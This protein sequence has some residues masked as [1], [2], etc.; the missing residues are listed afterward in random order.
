MTVIDWAVILAVGTL[1]ALIAVGTVLLRSRHRALRL[2]FYG[3]VG[4]IGVWACSWVFKMLPRTEAWEVMADL[5]VNES[6]RYLVLGQYGGF[7]DGWSVAFYVKNEAQWEAYYL[8]HEAHNWKD[9]EIEEAPEDTVV[10]LRGGAVVGDYRKSTRGFL[11]R[12][13]GHLYEEPMYAV[14]DGG[15]LRALTLPH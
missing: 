7:L 11:N 9:V 14:P 2:L 10:V 1:C 5:R 4:F 6:E 3:I 12:L 15:P 8:E 13:D